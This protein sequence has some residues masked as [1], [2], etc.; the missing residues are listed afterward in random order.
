[1][2][3]PFL[4]SKIH[5]ATVTAT[6]INYEGSVAIDEA[7]VE[8]ANLR[9]FQRVE[10][11]NLTNGNRFA[12]YVIPH[13]RDSREIVVN[14][15]AARLVSAGDK[16]IIA[17]YALIDEKELDALNAVVLQLGAGNEIERVLH[18]KF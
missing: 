10:I 1:M 13:R 11:Y 18:A 9:H 12:T 5:R 14:G 8:K 6:D 2:M 15:A 7:L 3:I 16:V 17:A 4:V